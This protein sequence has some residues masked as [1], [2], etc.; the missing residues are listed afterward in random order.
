MNSK[1]IKIL[2]YGVTVAG[3]IL[4]LVTDYVDDKKLD[5]KIDKK[6]DEKMASVNNEKESES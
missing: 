1:F 2:G 5:E 3:I 4:G 6:F